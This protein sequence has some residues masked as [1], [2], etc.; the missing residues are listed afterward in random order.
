[1]KGFGNKE[2][3]S[4]GTSVLPV[5]LDELAM[6]LKFHVIEDNLIKSILGTDIMRNEHFIIDYRNNLISSRNGNIR[7]RYRNMGIS[8]PPRQET[9]YVVYLT[10]EN[11]EEV[12]GTQEVSLEKQVLEVQLCQIAYQNQ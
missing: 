1:M 12:K 10:N 4:N 5:K 11:N 7:M 2:K 3:S 8:I 9:C 6:K